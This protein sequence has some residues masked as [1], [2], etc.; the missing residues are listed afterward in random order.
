M[1]A[2][3]PFHQQITSAQPL[4]NRYLLMRH[5][6][7]Q[8]NADHLIVSD[9]E[10]GRISSGLSS[11]GVTQL[12][13]LMATW[14]WPLPERILHSDFLRT[15]QTASSLA[16]HFALPVAADSRLRERHF[17]ELEGAPDHFYESVWAYDQQDPLHQEFGVES[18]ISVAN[19]MMA[20]IDDLERKHDDAVLMVVSH[21]DPLHILLTY[22]EHRPLGEHRRRRTLEPASVTLLH[23]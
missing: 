14:S 7:S 4:R 16:H 19:R 15:A 13:D 22:L 23:G 3:A 10:E 12:D 9:P 17:G 8:A 21:G 5:G 6:H 11:L 1:N 2:E 18:L 20:V